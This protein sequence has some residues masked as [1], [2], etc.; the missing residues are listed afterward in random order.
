MYAEG[1]GHV[2]AAP[3]DVTLRLATADDDSFLLELY[4]ANR[5]TELQRANWDAATLDAFLRSQFDTRQSQYDLRFP[6][7]QNWII[8]RG[9]QPVGR[10]LI[11]PGS[12]V[13]EFLDLGVLPS[14]QNQGIGSWVFETHLNEAISASARVRLC[15]R[16]ESPARRLYQRF[17]FL[18]VDSNGVYDEMLFDPTGVE[19]RTM[20]EV[21]QQG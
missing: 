14:C 12:T 6:R 15:V 20:R 10:H 16:S 17:R 1:H 21:I 3:K 2:A 4:R 5:F 7:A 9:E 19:E 13:W 18:V 11:Q 8:Q